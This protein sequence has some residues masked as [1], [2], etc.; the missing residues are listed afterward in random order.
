MIFGHC[1]CSLNIIIITHIHTQSCYTHAHAYAIHTCSQHLQL[2]QETWQIQQSPLHPILHPLSTHHNHHALRHQPTPPSFSSNVKIPS[3]AVSAVA[4]VV[5][6]PSTNL[7]YSPSTLR[8]TTTHSSS[9]QQ[10]LSVST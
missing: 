10:L 5:A 9:T 7:T 3:T 1:V 2:I 6:A 8:P 4:V